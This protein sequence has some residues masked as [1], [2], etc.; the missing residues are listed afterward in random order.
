MALI[1]KLDGAVNVS[2][3]QLEEKK[4]KKVDRNV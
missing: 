1:C 3:L 2:G 4:R